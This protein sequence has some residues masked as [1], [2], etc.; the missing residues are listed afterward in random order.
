MPV[1]HF[2]SPS[3]SVARDWP[4]GCMYGKVAVRGLVLYAATCIDDGSE[5]GCRRMG[6]VRL[7]AVRRKSLKIAGWAR[8]HAQGLYCPPRSLKPN[9]NGTSLRGHLAGLQVT[10]N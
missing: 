5:G 1:G 6:L 2:P 3:L 7:A 4:S 9:L 8:K 10:W